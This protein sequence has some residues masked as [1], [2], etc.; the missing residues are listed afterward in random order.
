MPLAKIVTN[1]T[2]G[3]D[4]AKLLG[5]VSSLLAARLG[6]PEA[7]VM[8]CLEPPAAMTFAGTNEPTAYVEIKNIGRF[9]PEKTRELSSELC[10][11]IGEALSVAPS[12]IYIEFSDAQGHLWGYDSETF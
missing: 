5:K 1:R 7:Y 10:A 6:K 11:L 4:P 2:P 9:T 3:S 12:R 8:T